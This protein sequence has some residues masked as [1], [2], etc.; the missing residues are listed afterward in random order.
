VLKAGGNDAGETVIHVVVK[1]A[2]VV[3]IGVDNPY[4]STRVLEERVTGAFVSVR[5][6]HD[7]SDDAVASLCAELE[8]ARAFRVNR[9]PLRKVLV[10]GAVS[11]VPG[12][13]RSP[14]EVARAMVDDVA[15]RDRAALRAYVDR[16]L[17]EAGL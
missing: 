1:T 15:S 8:G 10:E 14:G 9:R 13:R 2:P 7:A 11:R 12:P 16:K 3:I 5:P 4:W 6:P 17:S